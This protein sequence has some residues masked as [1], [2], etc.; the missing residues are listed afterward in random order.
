M[1]RYLAKLIF[2]INTGSEKA[3]AEFD[4]QIRIIEAGSLQGA[5]QKA[6][7]IGRSEETTF[8]DPENRPVSW[9]FID[10]SEVYSLEAIKDGEQLYSNTHMI[11][12]SG[13][14]IAYI[15]RRSMEIQAKH[16]LLI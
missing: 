13:A 9:Q 6:R 12:D 4:E 11:Q 14:F 7:T 10:V 8:L 1:E 15:R 5:F 16:L 3:V 2:N